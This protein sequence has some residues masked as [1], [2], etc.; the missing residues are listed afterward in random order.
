MD[1]LFCFQ[2]IFLHHPHWLRFIQGTNLIDSKFFEIF[3]LDYF[4]DNYTMSEH[5]KFLENVN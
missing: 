3:V 1:V 5:K 2:I 4:D